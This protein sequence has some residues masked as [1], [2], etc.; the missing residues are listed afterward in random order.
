MVISF[1]KFT[2]SGDEF[3]EQFMKLRTSTVTEFNQLIQEL[4]A[5]FEPETKFLIDARAFGFEDIITE[6]YEDCDVFV[7]NQLL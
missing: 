2:I 3:I 6:T 5:S 1:T 4:K 7:S